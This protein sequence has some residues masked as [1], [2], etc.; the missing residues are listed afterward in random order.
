MTPNDE[1]PCNLQSYEAKPANDQ[2][3]WAASIQFY[4]KRQFY[5]FT[6]VVT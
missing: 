6:K 5:G 4:L 1:L 2:T 3:P